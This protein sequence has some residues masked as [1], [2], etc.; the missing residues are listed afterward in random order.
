M[1]CSFCLYVY[2]KRGYFHGGKFRENVSIQWQDIS[3]WGKFHDT[4]SIS[5]IKAYGFYF[6]VQVIFAKKTKRESYHHATITMVTV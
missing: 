5:F 6:C 3:R 1:C 2:C 4:T